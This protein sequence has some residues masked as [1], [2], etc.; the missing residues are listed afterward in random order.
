MSDH[1]KHRVGDLVFY[2]G[3]REVHRMQSNMQTNDWAF[4]NMANSVHG[5]TH[6][7]LPPAPPVVGSW[8]LEHGHGITT[9]F[10]MYRRPRW[11]TRWAMRVVF[12]I[13][14]RDA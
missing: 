9:S 6:V 7:L 12:D 4:L 5:A 11:L 14:W 3:G 2:R 1:E 13:H 8:V 10:P